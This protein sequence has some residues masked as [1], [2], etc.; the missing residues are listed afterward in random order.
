MRSPQEIISILEERLQHAMLS[1]ASVL[2][3]GFHN[4]MRRNLR[5]LPVPAGAKIVSTIPF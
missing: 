3:G 2:S 4:I 5:F 1:N